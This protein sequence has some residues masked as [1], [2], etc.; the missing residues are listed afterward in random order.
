MK[1]PTIKAS[2]DKSASSLEQTALAQFSA[3]RYKEATDLYKN[4]LKQSDNAF[5]RQQL[6]QCYLQRALNMAANNMSKEAIILWENY[7]EWVKPPLEAL[8]SYILWQLAA[9]NPQKAY[10][11]LQQLTAQDLDENYLELA[12]CLG[13]F[14]ITGKKEI[15]EHLPQNS[16]FSVHLGLAQAALHAYYNQQTE[17]VDEALKKLPFRS[18]FRDLRA[19]LKAQLASRVSVEQTQTLLSKIPA[20]SPY[21]PVAN[22]LLAYS[23]TGIAFVETIEKLDHN[24]RRL[25]VR[26]KGLSKLQI[27]LLETLNKLKGSQNDKLRFNLVIQ[28]RALFGNKAAQDYCLSLLF[29]YPGGLKDYVKNFNAKNAFEENRIQALLHEQQ[30]KSYDAL[31]Y[32]RQCIKILQDKNPEN[33]LKIALILRRMSHGLP[34]E[35]AVDLIIES[36]KYDAGDRN[37]YL[38]ILHIYDNLNPDKYES[39]LELGLQRFP[40]DIDLLIRAAKFASGKKAFKKAASYAKALL[41]IDPVN[42]MAKQLLFASHLAHA[43][44]LIKTKKFHLVDKEIQAAE[45]LTVDKSQRRLADLLRGFKILATEATD[46]GLHLIIDSLKK[47]NEDPITMQFQALLESSLLELPVAAISKSLPVSKGSLLSEAHLSRLI[48]LIKYYDEQVNNRKI[49]FVALDK[50]KVYVKKSIQQQNYSEERLLAWC[51]IL[52]HIGHFE[53]LTHCAKLALS[54]CKKPIWVYFQVYAEI[55]GDASQLGMMSLFKLKNAYE[56]ACLAN[57]Q[58][59]QVTISRL[60]QQTMGFDN[61][62]DDIDEEMHSNMSIFDELFLHVPESIMDKLSQQVPTMMMKTSPEQFIAKNINKYSDLANS[63]RLVKLFSNPEF[64]AA[65]IYLDVAN[66]LNIDIG[67]TIEE[68]IDRFENDSPQL[69]LPFF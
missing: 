8:D 13:F 60:M 40:D 35:E 27:D 29:S 68:I 2:T 62:Y 51:R 64:M 7:A 5:F 56:E 44:R 39:W 3:K 43:R 69:S 33:D 23:Q 65:V 58:K 19:L 41:K 9:K 20:H 45:Q 1:K 66:K 49:L 31:F 37:S 15:A 59:T 67:I 38:K 18:A 50:I 21:R 22:A 47:L 28:F 10:A 26:A 17:A 55:K 63:K 24:Q 30:Q 46:Q 61:P 36:L 42:T 12:V 34:D 14:I 16:A 52:E 53:L 57:D 11:K 4:L 6:A 32:W 54:K 48:E 25:I